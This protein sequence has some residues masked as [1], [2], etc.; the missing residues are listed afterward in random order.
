CMTPSFLRIVRPPVRPALRVTD[1][2]ESTRNGT[3]CPVSRP[4]VFHTIV[5]TFPHAQSRCNRARRRANRGSNPP[6]F[7]RRRA[8]PHFRDTPTRTRP[9]P[10]PAPP[11]FPRQGNRIHRDGGSGNPPD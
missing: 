9:G 2:N 5:E 11:R 8:C 6:P 3:I 10:G 4:P 1:N 7:G